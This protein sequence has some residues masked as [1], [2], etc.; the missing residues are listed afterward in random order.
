MR[1][2]APRSLVSLLELA[3]GSP[4][5]ARRILLRGLERAR[6]EEPPKSRT[7]LA[8]FVRDHLLDVLAEQVGPHLAAAFR[9]DLGVELRDLPTSMPPDV[10]SAPVSRRVSRRPAQASRPPREALNI[11]VV[12]GDKIGR[13]A[14]A[15]ALVRQRWNVTVADSQAD[16]DLQARGPDA[17]AARVDAALVDA[18]HPAALEILERLARAYPGLAV[19]VRGHD[20]AKAGAFSERLGLQRVEVVPGEAWADELVR[21]IRRVVRS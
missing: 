17:T 14:L 9:E 5:V 18:R 11:V 3:C 2:S 1:R 16:V 19:V 6:L 7:K 21:A 13:T 10:R 20:A 8:S 4:D 15:R 12:D